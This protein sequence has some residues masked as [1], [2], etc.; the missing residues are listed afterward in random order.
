MDRTLAVWVVSAVLAGGVQAATLRTQTSLVSFPSPSMVSNTSGFDYQSQ[1]ADLALDSA[2][3][4][5]VVSACK[6]GHIG[7][8]Q[9]RRWTHAANGWS[10]A[11]VSFQSGNG[12][13]DNQFVNVA[14]DDADRVHIVYEHRIATN[15]STDP[16]TPYL[17]Y[18]AWCTNATGATPLSTNNWF[19]PTILTAIPTNLQQAGSLISIGSNL[20]LYARGGTDANGDLRNDIRLDRA[21]WDGAQWVWSPVGPAVTNVGNNTYGGL[22]VPRLVYDRQTGLLHMNYLDQSS[23]GPRSQAYTLSPQPTNP[24]LSSWIPRVQLANINAT[25]YEGNG[26][27]GILDDGRAV[28]LVYLGVNRDNMGAAATNFSRVRSA[29]VAGT[30]GAWT[31]AFPDD[32]RN[33]PGNNINTGYGGYTD[34]APDGNPGLFMVSGM[35]FINHWDPKTQAWADVFT[36]LPPTTDGAPVGNIG[37]V[38]AEWPIASKVYHYRRSDM[39]LYIGTYYLAPVIRGVMLEIR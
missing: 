22:A 6:A 8:V 7:N 25:W 35:G 33:L 3:N 18:H 20:L 12:F 23:S 4:A 13:D 36:N 2:G 14:V 26:G 16:T 27:V 29:G 15:T 11:K 5:H 31:N 9:Y 30:W 17:L 21:D 34:F 19:G 32:R 38:S 39:R 28:A 37:V 24:V 1:Y 10:A